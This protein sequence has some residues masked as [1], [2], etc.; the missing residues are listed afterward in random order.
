[1]TDPEGDPG[2]LGL[3]SENPQAVEFLAKSGTALSAFADGEFLGCGGLQVFPWKTTAEAWVWAM[4]GVHDY[5]L[6]VHK[7]VAR[8]LK[9]GGIKRIQCTVKVGNDRAVRW[10]EIL[11][12]EREGLMK[13]YG[14]G[15]A[16]FYMYAKVLKE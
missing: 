5:P 9:Q 16:D 8:G 6:F 10:V 2:L 13:K 11:G 15:G 3:L 12:F 1:M 4:P 14:P 7:I